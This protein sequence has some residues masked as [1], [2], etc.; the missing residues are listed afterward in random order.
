M[1]KEQVLI[2][3]FGGQYKELIARRVR[4]CGV[5]STLVSCETPAADIKKQAPIGII[6]TGGPSSVY[7]KDAPVCEPEVFGLG[8]P[9]LGICYGMQLL[10][11]L[12]GGQV[13]SCDTSEYGVRQAHVET[14]SA[15]FAG[16]A[17]EQQVLMSHTDRIERLPAGFVATAATAHCPTAACEDSARRL[18]GVQFHPEVVHTTQGGDMLH[19]FLYDICGA[20][21]EYSMEN[22][23]QAQIK[24]VREQVGD[25]PVLLGLSGGVDSSVCAAL[26]SEAVPGQLTCIYID[27]GFMRKNE[28]EQVRAVFEKRKLHFLAVDAKA[29]FLA[30][31]VGVTDPETKRKRIGEEFARAFEDEARKLG[32]LGFLA[33]GTIYP[34]IVESGK[35]KSAVIKSHHNVGGLPEKL[36]FLGVVEPLAGLFKDEVRKVGALLGLPRSIVQ[37]QPFPGPGLAIRVIGEVTEEKLALLREA[38][39]IF[40][41]EMGRSRA[42]ADQYFA[43]LTNTRSVGVMGDMRTYDYTVALRAVST[44]DFM[45][46]AYARLPYPLLDRVSSRITAEVRGI[47]RVVYDITAKPP[48]TIE[49][50]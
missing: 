13:V 33:Q 50:E 43:V 45:T 5:L 2:L 10:T 30:R 48:A 6:L 28:T 36:G 24:A 44:S 40:R 26:L 17:A 12:L 29:R 21:G 47:N 19:R 3:D 23:I 25:K 18:Y 35:N 14:S 9:V 34:D 11:H 41:E 27:H 7:A 31:L 38:D 15:L 1:S 49:W 39:A 8:I 32:E 37:R 46:C 16:M 42:K 22:Y 20:K 4:E